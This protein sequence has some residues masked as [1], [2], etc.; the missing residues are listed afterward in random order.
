MRGFVIRSVDQQAQRYAQADHA[1]SAAKIRRD[2]WR[3]AGY[4]ATAAMVMGLTVSSSHLPVQIAGPVFAVILLA[5]S[6]TAS[7]SSGQLRQILGGG[8]RDSSP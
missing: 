6:L 1:L 8:R 4:I 5:G 3:L 2:R 7:W